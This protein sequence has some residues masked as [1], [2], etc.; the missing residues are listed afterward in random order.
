M[1]SGGVDSSS[2]NSQN[3][4]RCCERVLLAITSHV[5]KN[6]CSF[7]PTFIVFLMRT[8]LH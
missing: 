4:Q 2:V 7:S 3:V 5:E 6:D 1:I 8:E